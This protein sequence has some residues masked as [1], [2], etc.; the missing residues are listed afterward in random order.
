MLVR[1]KASSCR[2]DRWM[3]VSVC[4]HLK[5]VDVGVF[6]FLRCHHC[7]LRHCCLERHVCCG[8]HA[9]NG[10]PLLQTPPLSG[11]ALSS[12]IPLHSAPGAG[13]LR[14]VALPRCGQG[15]GACRQEKE[16]DRSQLQWSWLR[17]THIAPLRTNFR[18]K[19]NRERTTLWNTS[20]STS[21]SGS[22][23]GV[24]LSTTASTYTIKPES[25]VQDTRFDDGH[26]K[27]KLIIM[28]HVWA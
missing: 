15:I 25:K 28:L 4:K 7:P 16:E 1:G 26:R 2:M 13:W 27:L 8:H 19:W 14:H 12:S 21:T 6:L 9:R 11:P 10:V 3:N 22:T 17:H 24:S 23:R 18:L 5:N 20:K